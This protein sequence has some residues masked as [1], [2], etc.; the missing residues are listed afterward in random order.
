MFAA[1]QEVLVNTA[2][3]NFNESFKKEMVRDSVINAQNYKIDKLEGQL[4]SLNKIHPKPSS[5][6]SGWI[7]PQTFYG[8]ALWGRVNTKGVSE[9]L[10]EALQAFTGPNVKITSLRRNWNSKSQHNHGRAVDLEF[11][12]ALITWLVS[13]QGRSW[14]S[15]HN[16]MFYIEDKPG[17]RKLTPYKTDPTTSEFVFENTRATGAHIH[18]N[19]TT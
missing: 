11:N 17:S 1:R 2:L 12:H 8:F 3:K 19:I 7:C 6:R 15:E 4:D 10:V 9:D 16:L 13:E 18:I 14:L 5:R